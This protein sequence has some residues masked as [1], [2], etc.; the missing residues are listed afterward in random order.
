M[1]VVHCSHNGSRRRAA[2]L[3]CGAA[4]TLTAHCAPTLCS[5]VWCTHRHSQ[6]QCRTHACVRRWW[7]TSC[8]M[9]RT[10]R[11]G[12]HRL[13]EA[14]RLWLPS[15]TQSDQHDPRAFSNRQKPSS[16]LRSPSHLNQAQECIPST[17]DTPAHTTLSPRRGGGGTRP[18]LLQ[19]CIHKQSSARTWYILL[20]VEQVVIERVLAPSDCCILV[21]GRVGE[22]R[23]GARRAAKDAT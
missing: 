4:G 21:G 13:L 14:V 23:S 9:H 16:C 8:S 5:V 15:S 20:G 18:A 3:R 11:R 6:Q 7:N 19:P 12:L 2:Q 17:T 22:T 10:F 1:V